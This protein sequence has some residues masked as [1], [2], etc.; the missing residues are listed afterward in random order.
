L[1]LAPGSPRNRTLLENGAISGW[2]LNQNSYFATPPEAKSGNF[3]AKPLEK[4]LAW[5]RTGECPLVVPSV[6][7]QKQRRCSLNNDC[8]RIQITAN[9]TQPMTPPSIHNSHFR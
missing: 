3:I 2:P 9:V 5:Q 4:A 6:P 7:T 1:H 8:T